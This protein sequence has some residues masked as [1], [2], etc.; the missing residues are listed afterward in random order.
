MQVTKTADGSIELVGKRNEMGWLTQTLNECCHGFR[1]PD[2]AAKIGSEK[3][4]VVRLLDD[5]LAVIL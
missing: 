5:I 4:A 3:S 1:M 2:F